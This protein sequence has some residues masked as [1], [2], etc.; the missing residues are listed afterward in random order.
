MGLAELLNG[1]RAAARALTTAT[2]LAAVLT[3]LT[4][5]A[6][7]S[8]PGQRAADVV[9]TVGDAQVTLAEVKAR[10]P[11]EETGPP[12]VRRGVDPP[13]AWRS[14]LDLAIRD[15]LLSL[16]AARRDPAARWEPDPAGRAARIRAVVD[17]ERNASPGLAASGIADAEARSWLADN[18]HVFEDIESAAVAWASLA[19]A[20]RARQ[21][22]DSAVGLDQAGFLALA[23]RLGAATGTA[24]LDSSGGG[25][26]AL[27]ARVAFA[28]RT[29]GSVGLTTGEDRS[30]VVRVD[31]VE[32]SVPPWNDA[33]AGRVR[34]AMAWEREQAHLDAL[35]E[36]LRSRWPVSVDEQRFAA[37]RP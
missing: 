28:V 7:C 22:L 3:A 23:A 30:W 4:L 14:A 21:L 19:D 27:V 11:A 31:S 32:I 20:G 36:Q 12:V 15:E 33:L 34:T 6:S 18:L 13:D 9:A 5:L 10:L 8:S 2:A 24:V 35:A 17:Q 26:D 1:R 25:A 37:S 29:E 16:E